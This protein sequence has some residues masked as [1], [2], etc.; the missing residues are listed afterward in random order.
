ML[1]RWVTTLA[2][3]QAI[4]A[5]KLAAARMAL[6]EAKT[7]DPKQARAGRLVGDAEFNTRFVAFGKGVHNVFYAGDL[8]NLANGWLDEAMHLLGKAPVKA[9]DTL[10]RGGYCGVLCHEQARV[11]FRETVTFGTQR[12]PHG[13]HVAEFGAVCTACHSAE[14]HKAVTATPATCSSCHH[15]P[16]NDRCESCHRAQ[17]AFYRGQV[18][19]TLVK[20]EPNIMA[21]AVPCTGCHDFSR[22]HSRRAVGEKCLGCHEAPYL[23]LLGEWTA[24]FDKDAARTASALQ[25]AGTAVA[26]ARQVGTPAAGAEALI[27]DARE[28]LGLVR[29]ARPAHNPLAADALLELAR[30]K[31]ATA[32]EEAGRR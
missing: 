6:S 19:T 10:V 3:M 24:G 7:K 31:A 26:S 13:R 14:V 12:V 15:S 11:K 28:A 16:Q 20:V 32:R 8:L 25:Q 4:I 17:A 27:K 5:P 22:K 18:A 29:A 30:Q 23:A 21:E 9:D 2:R 1:E